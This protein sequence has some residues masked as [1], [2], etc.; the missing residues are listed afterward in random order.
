VSEVILFNHIP[1]TAGTTMKHVLWRAV[2]SDRVLTSLGED[3][4]ERVAAIA[5]RLDRD[6]ERPYAIASHVGF[7]VERRLP[8]RH[9]YPA[10]TFLRD[11]VQRTISRYWH[12]RSAPRRAAGLEPAQPLE[13]WLEGEVLH[14]YNAQTGFLGGLWTRHH[15]DGEP[16]ERARFDRKLLAAAKRNLET[17][18]VV[19]LA[20]RFDESML[21][22]GDAFGW[23]LRKTT[24][25]RA[26]GRSRERELTP[27]ELEAVR[28]NNELDLELY[29][30]GRDLFESRLR[31][32]CADRERRLRRYR[33]ANRAYGRVYPVTA[34]A[35][36][37]ARS[38][39]GR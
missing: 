27:R 37:V 26:N 25:R 6:L 31:A 11:P 1:K 33:R 29:E 19:G 4:P 13:E 14:R 2:G 9:S 3:H 18:V 24:Y 7:G 20:E 10:F 16:L 23:P 35:R 21:L 36:A 12:Y 22:L 5:A 17:H 38:L 30:F 32:R 39:R 15:L 34:P 28:A 8:A